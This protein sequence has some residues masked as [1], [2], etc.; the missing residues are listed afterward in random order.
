M[1]DNHCYDDH[2][3]GDADGYFVATA[4]AHVPSNRVSAEW[5]HVEANEDNS[6]I[7]AN[8]CDQHYHGVCLY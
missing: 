3:D 8:Y 4:P 6:L 1:T 7:R 5:C 2:D